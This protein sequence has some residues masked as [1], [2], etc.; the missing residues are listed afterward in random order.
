M[1]QVSHYLLLCVLVTIGT[2]TTPV[3][4]VDVI[5]LIMADVDVGNLRKSYHNK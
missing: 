2:A 1:K 3:T 4:P 5:N